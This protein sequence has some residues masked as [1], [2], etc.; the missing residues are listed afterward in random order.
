MS[1]DD[2]GA[3]TVATSAPTGSEAPPESI[4]DR[5][6]PPHHPKISRKF[7]VFL[8]AFLLISQSLLVLAALAPFWWASLPV[9]SLTG[10]VGWRSRWIFAPILGFLVAFG[11]W[12]IELLALPSVAR[13][14]LANVLSAALGLPVTG[15]YLIG[16]VLLAVLGALA[17]ATVAGGL[18]LYDDMT[19]AETPEAPTAPR[20]DPTTEG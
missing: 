16:P 1:G 2:K 19:R 3:A 13:D 8:L 12:G 5:F 6:L 9:L 7:Q 17:A 15:V 18:R 14:R 11:Y 20:A 4:G 10:V